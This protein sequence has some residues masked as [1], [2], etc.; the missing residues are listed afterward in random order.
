MREGVHTG[1]NEI[2]LRKWEPME[3]RY[4]KFWLLDLLESNEI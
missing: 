3:L 2:T 1:D 4:S